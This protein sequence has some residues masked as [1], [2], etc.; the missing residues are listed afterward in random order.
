[1]S[2]KNHIRNS[3]FVKLMNWQE[4]HGKGRRCMLLSAFL[5][6]IVS[7]ISTGS[8]YTAFL[9]AHDFSIAD[10]SFL[11]II[12]SLAACF[13]VLSP[14]FLERFQKRRWLLAGGRL[15]YYLLNLLCLTLLA[16]YAKEPST[17]LWGFSL[18]LL[19]S[20]LVNSL[21]SSGYSVWHLNFMPVHLRA[22]YLSYQQIITTIASV[23]SLFFFGFLADALKG[24]DYEATILTIMRVVAFLFALVELA[25]LCIPK[26]YP[27]PREEKTIRITNIIRLPL[28]HKSFALSMAVIAL[29]NFIAAFPSSAWTYHLLESVGTGVTV[30][31]LF[32]L[33]SAVC[34]VTTPFW[35][36]LIHKLSWFQTFAICALFN[37]PAVFMMAFV[38]PGNYQ[39]LYVSSIFFQALVGI[40]LNLAWSNLPFVNTPRTDQTYYLAFYTL[41]ANLGLFLGNAAGAWFV[42]AFSDLSFSLFGKSFETAPT[43]I[44]IQSCMYILCAVFILSNLKTLQP[45]QEH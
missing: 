37:V 35:R 14:V 30:I 21:F 22:K 17:R 44:L 3:E 36:N 5:S 8:L 42:R 20:N 4:E 16:I 12:P 15:V 31:N 2:L 19:A 40:G 1:M 23:L 9:A 27:Y 28:R 11:A 7:S 33:F 41:T 43:M 38:N 24:T 39:W 10:T 34:L 45:E 18:I 25:V 26:E 32:H 29:W 6:T 13:C